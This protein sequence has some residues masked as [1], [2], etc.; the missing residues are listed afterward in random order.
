MS[1][2]DVTRLPNPYASM[3][4]PKGPHPILRTI[5]QIWKEIIED[6]CVDLAAAMAYF[7]VLALFPFFIVLGALAGFL[8][9][10]NLWAQ[11][12]DAIV[13]HYS[14]GSPRPGISDVIE[15]GAQE[16]NFPLP[17]LHRYR[18]DLFFWGRMPHGK[19]QSR[20][21]RSPKRAALGEKVDRFRDC[22]RDFGVS[23]RV[24]RA[25]GFPAAN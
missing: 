11:V 23:C 15:F 16:R 20:V 7:F 6:D 14:A 8:P 21:W 1:V 4:A 10:S 17:R 24:L 5:R 19:P 3:S 25:I 13:E 2:Y 22:H 12:S 18:M 9:Y